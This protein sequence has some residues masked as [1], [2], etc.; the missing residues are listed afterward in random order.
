[1]NSFIG[2]GFTF[3][4]H[5]GVQA[6]F[7]TTRG[8]LLPRGDRHRTTG[9]AEADVVLLV[10]NSPLEEALARLAREYPVVEP[11]Y[12]VSADRTRTTDQER[13][14]NNYIILVILT[15]FVKKMN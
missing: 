1:M 12:L 11:G 15:S 6:L 8:A 7:E 13:W 4:H 9:P 5:A 3:E 10:L 2:N 14:E